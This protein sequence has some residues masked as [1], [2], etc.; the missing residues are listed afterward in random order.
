MDGGIGKFPHL[1]Y[2]VPELKKYTT[3]SGTYVIPVARESETGKHSN[4]ISQSPK[5]LINSAAQSRIKTSYNHPYANE[6]KLSSS[7]ILIIN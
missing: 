5:Q 4:S 7:K 2:R 3:S 6:L 1:L